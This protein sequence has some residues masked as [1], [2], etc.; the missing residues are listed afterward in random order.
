M[1]QR[2]LDE[3]FQFPS[4]APLQRDLKRLMAA[5]EARFY[6]LERV[7]GSFE[8]SVE[9]FE[10]LG[11]SR[12]NDVLTPLASEALERLQDIT[13][14]FSATSTTAHEIELGEKQFLI[15]IDQRNTFA[16]TPYLAIFANSEADVGM[17]AQRLDFAREA[18]ILTVNVISLIGSG[19]YSD[20][21]ISVS[22][23]PAAGSYTRAETDLQISDAVDALSAEV[24]TA[25]GDKAPIASPLFTGNPRGPT[26]D[27][28]DDSTRLATTAW[29]AVKA[30]QIATTIAEQLISELPASIIDDVASDAEVRGATVGNLAMV[31]SHLASA[32]APV[33]LTDAA[34]INL[35][36]KSGFN[37]TVTLG[38]NRTLGNPSNGIP[39]TWRTIQVTQDANGTRTLNYGNQYVFPGGAA[40]KPVIA[41]GNG[42]VSRISIYC[43]ATN[44]FEVY[45][46][47]LGLSAS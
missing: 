4:N 18:G 45:P 43:R 44:I 38:G 14:L 5:L 39:G 34:T 35:D 41:T 9:G 47:G 27:A 22:P 19:N 11:L 37:F 46:V 25:L 24:V 23:P 7:Q 2:R 21:E 28:G 15:P 26:P 6:D 3:A 10:E 29:V 30:A 13:A 8:D 32:S 20:W 16:P 42:A 1:P 17:V 40:R 36:W 33:A 12:L 31:A